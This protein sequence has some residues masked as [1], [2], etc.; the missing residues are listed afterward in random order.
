MLNNFY[1]F[2]LK[3]IKADEHFRRLTSTTER[4]VFRKEEF[5]ETL[6][7]HY[8]QDFNFIDIQPTVEIRQEIEEVKV[9]KVFKSEPELS[10]S[11]DARNW[12]EEVEI[13]QDESIEDGREVIEEVRKRKPR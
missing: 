13:E 4:E 11:D 12:P 9:V 7:D 1:D 3:S 8:E 2:R 10:L 6:T 5:E